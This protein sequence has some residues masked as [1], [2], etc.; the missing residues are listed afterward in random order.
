MCAFLLQSIMPVSYTHLDVYKRQLLI[1]VKN[2][3]EFT[4]IDENTEWF[5]ENEE[6]D[7]TILEKIVVGQNVADENDDNED[8]PEI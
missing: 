7:D 5:N 2:Q 1:T 3:E 4:Q 8:E 6:W